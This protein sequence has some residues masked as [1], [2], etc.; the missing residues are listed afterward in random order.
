MRYFIV[1]TNESYRPGSW[2]EMLSDRSTGKA[3]AYHHRKGSV[4]RIS[5]GDY[6]YLYHTGVGVIAKGITTSACKSAKCDSVADG[7][8]YVQLQ[9]CWV[10]EKEDWRRQAPRASDINSTMGTQH[11]FRYTVFEIKDMSCVIDCIFEERGSLIG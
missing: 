5:K 11:R 8:C 10:I 2:K 7:E 3:S 1:N 9:F 4:S 6:V